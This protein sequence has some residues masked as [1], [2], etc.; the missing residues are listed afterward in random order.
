LAEN[1]LLAGESAP[2]YF[3]TC[4]VYNAPNEAFR[5]TNFD[6][7]LAVLQWIYEMTDDD[8]QQLVCEN[9][10]VW[11][12]RELDDCWHLADFKRFRAAAIDAWNDWQ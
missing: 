10:L 11:L 8:I 12:V 3:I 7:V 1:F 9:E 6:T 4:L 2:S 5:G